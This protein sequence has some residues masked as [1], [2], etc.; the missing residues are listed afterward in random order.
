MESSHMHSLQSKHE[1]LERQIRMEMNR[2]MPDDAMIQTLKKKK[3]RI[4]EELTHLQ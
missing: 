2:P 4:K 3:L 1:G